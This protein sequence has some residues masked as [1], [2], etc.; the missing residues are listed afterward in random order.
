MLYITS[1]IFVWQFT[2]II[3]FPERLLELE[4]DLI[5]GP[6]VNGLDGGH[7]LRRKGRLK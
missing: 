6:E 5:D 4:H 3:M 2:R 7:V 1:Y